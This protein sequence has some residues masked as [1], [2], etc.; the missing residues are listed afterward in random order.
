[1]LCVGI[2]HIV[3]SNTASAKG[4]AGN[5]LKPYTA[6]SIINVVLRWCSSSLIFDGERLK[7]QALGTAADTIIINNACR[8][9]RH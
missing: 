2:E 5:L 4:E 8:A 1:M 9:E 3:T 6:K 7:V